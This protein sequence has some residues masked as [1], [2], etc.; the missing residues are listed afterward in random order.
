MKKLVLLGFIIMV[1]GILISCSTPKIED[2]QGREPELVL[3]N[4][5]AGDLLAYGIVRD[6]SGKVIRYFKAVLKGSW[7]N[8]VGTLDEVFW[9]ND[10]KRE[11]RIWTMQPAENGGYIGTAPDVKG[12][13]HI[14]SSGNAVHLVYSLIVPYKDSTITLSMDDW[15]YQVAPGIVINE[16]AMSKWGFNVGKVTLVIARADAAEHFQP[17]IQQFD[18]VPE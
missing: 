18:V 3:E 8:G 16:T 13:A 5:F 6:R 17:L 14:R 7:D 2:Y 10:G 15:M 11:T 9:F 4:F 1:A 12:Q